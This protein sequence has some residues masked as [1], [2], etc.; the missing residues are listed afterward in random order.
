MLNKRFKLCATALAIS[1]V[2]VT[3]SLLAEESNTKNEEKSIERIDIWSTSVKASSIYLKGEAI[4]N[5][6]ADHIS[7]LLRTIPG[8]DVG[9]AHSLNQRITIRSM[10]DKDLDISIDGAKQNTYMYHHMGNLQIHADILKSVDIEVGTNSV[11]NGGLGGS[12]R[13]ETKQAKAL[14]DDNEKFGARFQVGAGSNSGETYSATAYGLLGDN[15]DFLGYYNGVNRD[16]YEVGG[17]EIKDSSG[18]VIEGTDGTV[19]GIEGQLDD[20]LIKFGWEPT[21]NQRVQLSYETYKDKGDYSYRPDMGLATDLAITE[22]LE[23][24]LLWPTEFTRDTL[25]LNYELTLG[26]TYLKAAVYSNTSELWRDETGYADNPSYEGWA[27]IVTG[28]AKNTGVNLIAETSFDGVLSQDLTYGFDFVKHETAYNAEYSTSVDTSN[29]EASNI[30]LF[31]QDRVA[32]TD[33]FAVIPGVRYDSYDIDSTVVN[34]TFSNTAFSLALE[35]QPNDDLLFKFSATELF[36]GPEIGEVFVGAGL[37]DSTNENIEAE[38]GINYELS[39]AYQILIED[40]GSVSLGATIFKTSIDNYIYDYATPPPEVGGRSWKDNIG[41]MEID[42]Y[43][44]YINYLNGQ[45]NAGITYSSAESEL[46]AFDDYIDLDGARLDRQQGNTISA[47]A[48]YEL[49]NLGLSVNWEMLWVD[50]VAANPDLDGASLDNS[51]DGYSVHNINARWVSES[52]DG[53]A[54]IVGVDNVF[55]EFY[56]SQSSRTGVSFHPRFGELYLQ[57]FEPGRNIKATVSYQF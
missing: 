33:T 43:E 30:A 47:N 42:G 28:E 51:K 21:D 18:N 44:S 31:I 41:D 24:P 26:D 15:V 53:L 56:S 48:G 9:G 35:L 46:S 54:I 17:G 38:T 50:D 52:L 7:D 57:D 36:K 2:L 23:I 25:T 10:D 29:E 20:A 13:F 27:A 1:S 55:D 49:T 19:R 6:Q 22:S 34:N 45:F 11:I 4:A 37:Y 40:A 32:I 8:V 5:K 14:L 39:F 16:D 3:P 12:V